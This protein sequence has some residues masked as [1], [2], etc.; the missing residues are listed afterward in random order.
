MI[1][2]QPKRKIYCMELVCQER[3]LKLNLSENIGISL[4]ISMF[5]IIEMVRIMIVPVVLGWST[6]HRGKVARPTQI[7]ALAGTGSPR[8]EWL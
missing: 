4:I 3:S 7:K 2:A 5:V 1:A 6:A 8:K